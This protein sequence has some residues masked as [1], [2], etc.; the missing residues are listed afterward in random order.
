MH[1]SK[2]DIAPSQNHKGKDMTRTGT[3]AVIICMTSLLGCA[4][5]GGSGQS[6]VGETTQAF[7]ANWSYSWADS[8]NTFINIG[9]STNRTC[10]LSGLAG[11]LTPVGSNGQSGAGLQISPMG[12]YFMYLE[13][14]GGLLNVVAR[15]MN[16]SVGRTA[17]VVWKTGDPSHLLG[18]VTASRRCFLTSVTTTN[19]GGPG[20]V[21]DSDNVRVWQDGSNWWL[22]GSQS[23][24]VWATARCIDVSADLG[25]WLW[26]AGDPGS[27]Q[28][29]LASDPGGVSCLLT[30]VGGH[31]NDNDA[32]DGAYISEDSAQFHMNTKNGHSGW[33]NCV[34]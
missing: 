12:D 15:C 29:P 28:D 22:G 7:S 25:N 23:G 17:E 14:G 11:N 9:S 6:D 21:S 4:D 18:S 10:F 1:D 24:V 19:Q 3:W 31:F 8:K 30:G 13:S 33:A 32:T 27:R 26:V 2:L 34:Q 20:F 5:T 16:T